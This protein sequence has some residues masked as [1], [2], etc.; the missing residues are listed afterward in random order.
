[1]PA[2]F[3]FD[4]D[5]T[6]LDSMPGIDYSVRAAFAACGLEMRRTDLR[7]LIGP[8]I[9]TILAQMSAVALS[10]QQLDRL[11]QGFRESYDSEGW[12]LTPHFPGA[13]DALQHLKA[14]GTNLFVV[15][16]KPWHISERILEEEGTL[17]LF[18]E[19][20]TRDKREPG[21]ENKYQMLFYLLQKWQLHPTKC[22]MVG[23]TMEDAESARDAGMRFCFMAHGYGHVSFG[24]EI[25]VA[26]Q[27]D[28]FFKF[29]SLLDR[30]N[31]L[32]R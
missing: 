11:V 12:K 13:V 14:K 18:A 19:I 22:L 24:Q 10:P 28:G 17:S 16:N 2:N 20:V 3:F 7:G 8:P 5:G 31:E 32:D 25:P 26:F 21:F 4:L 6:L 15:S 30:S 29:M 1:M 9:R 23:D 27:F